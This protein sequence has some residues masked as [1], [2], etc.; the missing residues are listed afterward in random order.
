[1]KRHR[2]LTYIVL[3]GITAFLLFLISFHIYDRMEYSAMQTFLLAVIN[4]IRTFVFDPAVM[5][6]ELSGIYAEADESLVSAL[7]YVYLLLMLTAQILVSWAV[8]KTLLILLKLNRKMHIFE[9]KREKVVIVGL[10]AYVKELLQNNKTWQIYLLCEEK[11]SDE[12]K[13]E[14]ETA[15]ADCRVCWKWYGLSCEK[16]VCGLL[17]KLLKHADTLPVILFE[18]SDSRNFENYM[19][20]C[21]LGKQFEQESKDKI[22]CYASCESRAVERLLCDYYDDRP[23]E[24]R[25][26][27]TLFHVPQLQVRRMLAQHPVTEAVWER[28][29][30]EVT[31]EDSPQKRMERYCRNAEQFRQHVL[32]AGFGVMGQELLRQ[33]IT[34]SVLHSKA[35]ILIDVADR[36]AAA[37]VNA[38]MSRFDREYVRKKVCRMERGDRPF[39]AEYELAEPECDG[40]LRI[41]FWE[42]DILGEDFEELLQRIMELPE[43]ARCSPCKSEAPLTYAA[44]TVPDSDASIQGMLTIRKYVTRYQKQTRIPVAVRVDGDTYIARLLNSSM[45]YE[46]VFPISPGRNV[47]DIEQILDEQTERTAIRYHD[48]YD[49]VAAASAYAVSA[50]GHAQWESNYSVMEEKWKALTSYKRRS[51]R[52]LS[53]HAAEKRTVV[54]SVAGKE[55]IAYLYKNYPTVKAMEAVLKKEIPGNPYEEF[56]VEM[57]RLEHRR[58]CYFMAA[59]G[60]ST[61]TKLEAL[62]KAA[63][64]PAADEVMR[65]HPCLCD[66]ELLKK[67]MGDKMIYDLIPMMISM[68]EEP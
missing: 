23:G 21:Q 30:R 29:A 49:R 48:C 7:M 1:M 68:G 15:Y 45:R 3:M 46:E 64:F 50:G 6:E 62:D 13:L 61:N 9:K 35:D 59:D 53:S 37:N 38:F 58:W 41:R 10:N 18:T 28:F 66:W 26:E 33:M 12:E 67:Y 20:L 43:D 39:M 34:L 16:A 4:S 17:K 25:L 11:Y 14:L 60:W 19:R 22:K 55:G 2:R 5:P 40:S 24:E 42:A 47:V 8:I 63:V 44:V 52:S 54:H 31:A 36:D 57:A 56:L 27:M 65:T 51:S 32:I